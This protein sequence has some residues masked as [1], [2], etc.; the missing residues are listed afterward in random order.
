MKLKRV[1]G[2][3]LWCVLLAPIV[4]AQATGSVT[5]VVLDETTQRHLPGASVKLQGSSVTT[6]TD[7]SGAFQLL[8]VPTGP[9]TIIVSYVGYEVVS[10][11]TE[12]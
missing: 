12:S 6:H 1:L 9:Q 7:R 8:R 2:S 10:I 3:I 5:G 11:E 4:C